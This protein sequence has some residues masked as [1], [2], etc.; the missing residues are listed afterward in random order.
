MTAR[1][2]EAGDHLFIEN[3][4]LG[5]DE[6]IIIFEGVIEL[7]TTMDNGTDF[8]IEKLSKGSVLNLSSFIVVRSMPIS[9]RFVTNTTYYALSALKF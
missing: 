7:Y 1:M 9:A 3:Q 6:L 4:T 2:Q 5:T 8:P